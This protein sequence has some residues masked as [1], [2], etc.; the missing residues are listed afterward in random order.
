VDD[1]EDFSNSKSEQYGFG[2]QWASTDDSVSQD[3]RRGNRGGGDLDRGTLKAGLMPHEFGAFVRSTDQLDRAQ[4]AAKRAGDSQDAE[5]DAPPGSTTNHKGRI[6][7]KYQFA[8][9]SIA[10]VYGSGG[11]DAKTCESELP[12]QMGCASPRKQ[13]AGCP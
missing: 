2:L 8:I 1:H 3:R 4:A 6:D 13:Y 5:A 11:G 12:H 9:D 10:A 7:V